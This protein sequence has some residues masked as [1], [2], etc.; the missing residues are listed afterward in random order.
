MW[1][2]L[3]WQRKWG[4]KVL[5]YLVRQST[6]Q[7]AVPGYFTHI[8]GA[9]LPQLSCYGVL[10]HQW[11]LESGHKQGIRIIYTAEL[12]PSKA[13]CNSKFSTKDSGI[14]NGSLETLY[15]LYI[16][17]RLPWCSGTAWDHLWT[18]IHTGLCAETLGEDFWSTPGTGCCCWVETLQLAPGPGSTGTAAQGSEGT[19][20][21]KK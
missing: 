14:L 16:C 12:N 5:L 10:F 11:F 4:V 9:E 7:H 2:C 15:F 1:P 8:T 20:S 19:W 3:V 17:V 18:E 6:L 21:L 13:R